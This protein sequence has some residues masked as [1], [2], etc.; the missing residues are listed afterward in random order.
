METVSPLTFASILREHAVLFSKSQLPAVRKEKSESLEA[1]QKKLQAMCG[2]NLETTTITKKIN[3]MKMRVKQKCDIN[4]TGN[5]KIVLKDWEKIIYEL[6]EGDTNPTVTR[7]PGATV[8]GVDLDVWQEVEP[9]NLP[10]PIVEVVVVEEGE[11]GGIPKEVV[12]SPPIST[13]KRKRSIFEE[14]ETEETRNFTNV[15][16]Q[17][18]VLL[19]QLR[20]LDLKEKKLKSQIVE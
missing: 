6:L 8:V 2:K 15:E 16:L 20:V 13:P 14:Y 17:R 5:K 19:K 9:D 10:P 7:V 12:N 18:L 3:N 1:V 4:K 11:E